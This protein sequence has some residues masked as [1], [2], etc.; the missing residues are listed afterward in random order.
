M[1][2]LLAKRLVPRRPT[3][4]LRFWLLA[5]FSK[6]ASPEAGNC[7]SLRS[8]TFLSYLTRFGTVSNRSS[9]LS[10]FFAFTDDARLS[11][12]EVFYKVWQLSH[13][14]VQAADLYPEA[15]LRGVCLRSAPKTLS[16]FVVHPKV[17]GAVRFL[18]GGFTSTAG[19][20]PG[21]EARDL[22][23]SSD[24][25]LFGMIISPKRYPFLSL[26]CWFY[27]LSRVY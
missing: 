20:V 23:I 12:T 3:P 6:L 13:V 27:M 9:S 10:P 26:R 21:N 2:F 19:Y 24:I 7:D 4:V 16:R 8:E 14:H 25:A 5:S 17:H 15:T 18:F 1:H 22:S 11:N